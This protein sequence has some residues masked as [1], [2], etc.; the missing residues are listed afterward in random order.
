MGFR[1][2]QEPEKRHLVSANS[3]QGGIQPQSAT[4]GDS[5]PKQSHI[6]GF[7]LFDDENPDVLEDLREII[8]E[9]LDEW[10]DTPHLKFGDK[11]PRELVGT[12]QEKEIR[13]LIRQIR[14]GIPT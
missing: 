9:E 1:V 8:G 4:E 2:D 6:P 7:E 5:M 11:K 13:I 14:D 10:L 3:G 12:P